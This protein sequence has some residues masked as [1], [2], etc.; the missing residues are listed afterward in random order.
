MGFF[1]A[2]AEEALFGG[3]GGQGESELV[4]S[5]GFGK[6]PE[7]AQKVGAGGVEE[8]VVLQAHDWSHQVEAG[9]GSLRHGDSDGFVQLD[10]GGRELL[11]ELAVE[12]RD[13]VPASVLGAG[14]FGVD[15]GDGGLAP[16]RRH[17]LARLGFRAMLAGTLANFVTATIAGFLL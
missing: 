15:G 9:L 3:V 6:A 16:S 4:G 7:A 1:E 5:V 2:L 14:G 10:D 11:R 17:D 12:C 13:F 8:V